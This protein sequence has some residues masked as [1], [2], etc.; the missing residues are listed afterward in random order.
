MTTCTDI[1]NRKLN[2]RIVDRAAEYYE[3]RRQIDQERIATL[4]QVIAELRIQ[5]EDLLSI[6]KGPK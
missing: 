2:P 3:R 5:I 4:E 1:D 6:E